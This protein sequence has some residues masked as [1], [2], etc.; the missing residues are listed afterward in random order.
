[1]CGIAGFVGSGSEDDL[2]RMIYE[3]H[4]RGP[5]YQGTSLVENVGFAHARLSI[6]D[7]S[8]NGNQPF[9]SAD[10]SLA[11]TFNGEIYN[12]LAL[13]EELLCTGKYTFRTS[14][15]TEVLLYL[16]QE[17]GEKLFD[18]INGM[19]AFAI[20]NFKTKQ[21]LLAKDRMGKKPLYYSVIDGT[22]VFASE[23]KAILQHPSVKKEL[24]IDAINEY[25][26]FDY[27]PTPHTIFKNIYKLE[28]SHYLVFNNGKISSNEPYWKTSFHQSDVSF[29]DAIGKFDSLLNDATDRRLMSDVPLGVFLSGGLDSSTIA[30][31]A[32]K[33]AK[34]KIKTFSIGFS[35]KSYDESNYAKQVATYLG[36]EHYEEFLSAEESLRLIPEIIPKLDEP[37]A[38][39]SIIPTYFL[40]KFT[41]KHVTV[42]L[43]GDGSDEL[44]AGYPTFISNKFLGFMASLP[45]PII[46]IFSGLTKLLPLSDKNISLDFKLTQFFKGF[47]SEKRYAHTLWLGSFTP[48]LKQRLFLPSTV[49]G[50]GNGLNCID[51]YLNDIQ[52]E[53]GFNRLLYTYYRTYLVEDILVKVDRASM[54]TSLEVRAPFLDRN[55]VDF[56]S[57]LPKSY[58]LKGFTGKHI[59]K[60]LMWGKLPE[61]IIYR[62]KKGFGIPVSLWLRNQLKGM[63]EYY[64]SKERIEK[65][66]IFNYQYIEQLK[67]E[68]FS[69]KRNHRKLLWNL[70]ILEMWFE[71]Y[72]D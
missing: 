50:N 2:K 13:K 25:L 8:P 21:L 1:M 60:E 12:Y 71:N 43:G 49:I 18:K 29:S 11:I 37:F 65:H 64:L 66:G 72:Y 56:L 27:I 4:H 38:D 69:M 36:T 45:T 53:F 22:I 40:S 5:D 35:E 17:H 9:F 28:A 52:S 33:N 26:T 67:K 15:D 59:L 46:K 68:H 63:L 32:Q 54:Y 58:K 20:Y 57:S 62:T 23:L 61:E 19:Y 70:L 10:S 39:P 3:L 34:S 24:N 51:R 30:Y 6:I 55:V 16:Y 44:L 42:A 41:R 31:Y 47:E 48:N 14:T 7:L